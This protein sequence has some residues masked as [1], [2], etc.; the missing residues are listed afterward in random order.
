MANF[1]IFIPLFY[2]KSV[3]HGM[4]AEWSKALVLGTNL[5]AWVRTP[6]MSLFLLKLWTFFMSKYTRIQNATRTVLYVLYCSSYW[7]DERL[8]PLSMSARQGHWSVQGLASTKPPT[9]APLL[10]LLPPRVTRAKEE[11]GWVWGWR[12]D[13][14]S[15]VSS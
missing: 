4:M 13:G 3:F 7:R 1:W 10:P 15:T 6:L 14:F 11:E 2:S 9:M 8:A 12:H 5:R